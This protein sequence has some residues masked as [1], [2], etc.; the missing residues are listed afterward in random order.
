MKVVNRFIVY[1]ALLAAILVFVPRP[2]L[3]LAEEDVLASARQLAYSGKEHRDQA[4]ALLKEYLDKEDGSDA[5]TLYGTVLSWQGRYDEA[6]VQLKMVLAAHP[7]HGDALPALLNVEFWS[8]HPENVEQLAREALARD[9]KNVEWMLAEAKALRKLNRE[10]EATKVLDQIL[11]MDHDNKDAAQMHREITV[12]SLKQEVQVSHSYDWFSDGRSGQHE[13]VLSFSNPT[14]LGSVLARVSRADRFSLVSYQTELEFY[15]HIRPGTYGFINVGYSYDA[16]LYPRYR[17]GADLFHNIGRGYEV[18]GGYRHLGFTGGVDIYTF[19]L[20]KYYKNFL[21]TGRGFV[22]PGAP[23]TSGTALFSARYFLGNEGLHDYVE[24]RYS[25]G[26]SPAQARTT[27]DI[28][29]LSSNRWILAYD[30]VVHNRF[31]LQFSGGAG[32]S[33]RV[34]LSNLWQYTVQ[35]ALYYRF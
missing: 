5:R 11:A 18:S 27:E 33:E 31:S 2:A 13:S 35:G 3:A 28:L 8:D 10:H 25:R 4:L 14:P 30:K 19:S 24:L 6:R 7:N 1:I 15:P 26:A 22:T 21:F 16:N 9:P 32:Q 20:A 29:V 34:G 23:G 17:V 12:D